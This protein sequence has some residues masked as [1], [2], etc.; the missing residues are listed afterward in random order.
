MRTT[1]PVQSRVRPGY[2]H[3]A[4][5]E[6]SL[7][8]GQDGHYRVVVFNVLDAEGKVEWTEEFQLKAV[9]GRMTVPVQDRPEP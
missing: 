7:R 9:P 2:V 5:T 3:P 6:V 1:T 8:Q 4:G